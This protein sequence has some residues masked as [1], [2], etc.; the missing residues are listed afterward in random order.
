MIYL[1]REMTVLK[2]RV[3]LA[4]LLLPTLAAAQFVPF[5]PIELHKIPATKH[6]ALDDIKKLPA[7][8]GCQKRYADKFLAVGWP[9]AIALTGN[10]SPTAKAGTV[11]CATASGE[12]YAGNT[13]LDN[14]NDLAKARGLPACKLYAV[15]DTV[16]WVQD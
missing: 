12:Q 5:V 8:A 10:A 2:M 9:R 16:V 13:A 11:F 7:G 3:L 15:N 14:C 4:S 1:E 6:A